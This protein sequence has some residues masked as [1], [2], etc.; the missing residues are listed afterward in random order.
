[1]ELVSC[2]EQSVYRGEPRT[3]REE[4]PMDERTTLLH[5]ALLAFS[6]LFSIVNPVS[7]APLFLTMTEGD[8]PDKRQRMAWRASVTAWTTLTL[9]ALL[10]EAVLQLFSITIGA[11]RIAGGALLFSIGMDMIRVQQPREKQTPEEIYE[12]AERDDVAI[13]PL[14]IPMLSGPGAISTVIVLG[15]HA[16]TWGRM[17]LLL[18]VIAVTCM[19]SYLI[20]R[21][22]QYVT[23]LLGQTGL[24]IASRLMGL[25]LTVTAVQFILNGVHDAL[26]SLLPAWIQRTVT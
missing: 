25:L 23:R 26:P 19:A 20:L 5:F 24:R 17:L 11:F 7:T 3:L 16:H 6:S 14:A 1:M 10:G 8:P 18:A 13:I 15:Q 12:G 21:S 2:L 4:E 22:S 9:F